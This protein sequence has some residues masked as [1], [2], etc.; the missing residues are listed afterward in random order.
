MRPPGSN[1]SRTL[2]R[3]Q[4]PHPNT[5]WE[6]TRIPAR[7]EQLPGH[8]ILIQRQPRRPPGSQ[9]EQNSSQDTELSC[10]LLVNTT[11]AEHTTHSMGG[12]GSRSS[13]AHLRMKK[14]KGRREEINFYRLLTTYLIFQQISSHCDTKDPIH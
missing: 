14:I 8:R 11:C 12:G 6:T 3:T 10:K 13:P 2:P 9:Q 1:K 4:S 5:T 7:G